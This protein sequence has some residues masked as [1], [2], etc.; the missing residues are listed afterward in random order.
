MNNIINHTPYTI[1]IL[2]GDEIVGGYIGETESTITLSFP[3]YLIYNRHDM[4]YTPYVNTSM[5][6]YLDL[7]KDKFVY[8]GN[9]IHSFSNYYQ[10]YYINSNILGNKID[11]SSEDRRGFTKVKRWNIDY[12]DE[13]AYGEAI[14]DNQTIRSF[15]DMNLKSLKMISGEELICQYLEFDEETKNHIVNYPSYVMVEPEGQSFGPYID[16]VKG[17]NIT[18][19]NSYVVSIFDTDLA[20]APSY[21]QHIE[22]LKTLGY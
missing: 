17:E 16:S 22:Y 1:K 9:T 8:H 14:H 11:L 20:Y 5:Y 12:D 10:N 19:N 18:I 15:L 2:N 13:N 6:H 7:Y 3:S 21:N 4:K